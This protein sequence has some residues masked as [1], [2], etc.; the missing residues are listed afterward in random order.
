MGIS[1]EWSGQGMRL[2][3]YLHFVS[4]LRMRGVTHPF[5]LY[6]FLACAWASLP[7]YN[8]IR[9]S[10]PLVVSFKQVQL[11]Q[12]SNLWKPL[13]TAS[14]ELCTVTCAS[15]EVRVQSCMTVTWPCRWVGTVISYH[16]QFQCIVSTCGERMEVEWTTRRPADKWGF[17]IHIQC[18]TKTTQLFISSNV[19]TLDWYRKSSRN[20]R[21][22]PRFK[23]NRWPRYG[24]MKMHNIIGNFRFHKRVASCDR[25]SP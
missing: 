14:T 10:W 15:L 18:V 3:A 9:L 8:E 6:V 23:I 20:I 22:C 17:R 13:D 7:F 21:L 24:V 19:G 25:W 16:Q 2:N 1:L 5:P 4:R 11:I 12:V